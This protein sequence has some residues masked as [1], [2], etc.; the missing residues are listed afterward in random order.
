MASAPQGA[1]M[2][3]AGLCGL[4]AARQS[5]CGLPSRRAARPDTAPALRSD[6]AASRRWSA[7]SAPTAPVVRRQPWSGR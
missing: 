3:A 7:R 2:L 6:W 5:P 4:L 1:T